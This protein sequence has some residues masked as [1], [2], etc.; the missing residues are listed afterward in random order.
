MEGL[1]LPQNAILRAI[2]C[3]TAWE[4]QVFIKLF[5]VAREE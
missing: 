5:L 3:P 2:P 4:E 1:W